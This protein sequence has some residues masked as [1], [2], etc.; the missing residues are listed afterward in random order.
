MTTLIA[1]QGDGYCVIAADSQTT[2]GHIASDCSPMG[3]IA[4]N[5]KFLVSA[6]GTVRGM[7]LIQHAFTPPA[8]PVRI[9][10][11]DD[12]DHYMITSFVPALRRS[13]VAAGYDI[14]E[15]GEI[16]SH[17]NDFIVAVKGHLFFVDGV[18]GIE[19]Y[20]GNIHITGSGRSL[21]LGAADAL[22]ID[23]CESYEEVVEIITQAVQTAIKHDIY[24]SGAVQIAV[25]FANGKTLMTTLDEDDE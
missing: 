14:K 2:Y 15:S 17:E 22:G 5:G 7:N 1:Y 21:A 24:S 23:E 10:N 4:T 25:Q 6:A 12:L 11:V 13:F 16:A 3:K 20:K 19:R 18:Y 8:L 9:K